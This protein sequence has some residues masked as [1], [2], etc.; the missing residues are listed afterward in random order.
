[1]TVTYGPTENAVQVSVG[2]E[3]ETPVVDERLSKIK[4]ML[5]RFSDFPRPG[6]DFVDIFP[7]FECPVLFQE[8]LDL[9]KEHIFQELDLAKID[10]VVGVELRGCLFG[11]PL[12]LQLQKPFVPVRKKGKL[13][14]EVINE[15]YETEYSADTMEMQVQS[16][17]PG[18]KVIIVDDMLATGGTMKTCLSL[19]GKLKCEVIE[20]LVIMELTNA[21]GRLN[22]IPTPVHSLMKF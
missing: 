22:V 8:L 11:V 5:R 12:A 20:C 16:M 13:P 14:G 4:G 7:V 2:K 6:V 10:Y 19:V 21:N 15:C 1:M 3:V 9:C 17:K 18:S